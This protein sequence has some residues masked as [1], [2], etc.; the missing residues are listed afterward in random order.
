[1]FYFAPLKGTTA[2]ELLS[3]LESDPG[4]WSMIY[5]DENGMHDQSDASLEVYRRLGL[6][7]SVL[8]LL[9]WIPRSIRN[10]MY[11]VLARNRYRWFGKRDACAIP[12]P[13][14]AARFLP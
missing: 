9:R 4:Q 1:V 7:W 12:S 13:G 2:Q 6:P 8:S 5:F 11:R 10:P 14:A 3:P